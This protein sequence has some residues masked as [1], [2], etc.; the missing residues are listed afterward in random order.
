[1]TGAMDV[2]KQ[3]ALPRV[4]VLLATYNGAPWLREQM[5]SILSQEGVDILV[6]IG[7]DVSR[8]A[9][10]ALIES[11]WGGGRRVQ[12]KGW[13]QSSGS[14]G[15][16]FRR[17]YREVDPSGFD[18]VALAD[19]DDVWMP[20]KILSAI[21][22]LQTT[23]AQGYSCAVQA[24][25]P[26]GRER[27]LAQ[28]E[29]LR[30][31]DFLFEGAGQGCTFVMTSELF[32]RIRQFCIV[33]TTATEALHYHDW[34]IYLLARAWQMPWHFDSRPWMRY[35]QHGGNEIGS[36]GSFGAIQ[37]RLGMIRNGW[38]GRQVVAAGAIYRLAKGADPIACALIERVQNR[39]P[40]LAYRVE[41]SVQ[42]LRFGR[43]RFADRLVLAG[44]A[45]LGWLL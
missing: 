9:T 20:R 18:Y 35:R 23:G 26:D 21:Q 41:L 24:F 44:S 8:D 16:N 31:A 37:R 28:R 7:D 29:N 39:V 34:L 3:S 42:I 6:E 17:L 38:F 19:Q 4:L 1:M 13:A 25:W 32:R 43:R 36:R 5:D 11:T 22:S 10:K 12:L 2:R 45:L 14:A 33:H 40:G 15:A 30:A 27:V